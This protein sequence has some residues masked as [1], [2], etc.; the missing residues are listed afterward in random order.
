MKV[1]LDECL[2][3]RLAKDFPQHTVATVPQMGWAGV[4]NGAL[5]RKA[6]QAFEVFITVDQNL[7][8]QQSLPTLKIAIIVLKAKTNRLLD[9][10]PMV[11]QIEAVLADAT[12]GTI[13]RISK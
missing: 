11:P 7:T 9:I 4:K 13:I 12:P 5:L 8:F 2:D 3:R 10:R 6:E 1:L